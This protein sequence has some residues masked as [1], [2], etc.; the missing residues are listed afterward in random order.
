MDIRRMA[1]IDAPI[2]KVSGVPMSAY[3]CGPD[4]VVILENL[5]EEFS[6]AEFWDPALQAWWSFLDVYLSSGVNPPFTTKYYGQLLAKKDY[7]SVAP[8]FKSELFGEILRWKNTSGSVIFEDYFY[9]DILAFCDTQCKFFISSRKVLGKQLYTPGVYTGTLSDLLARG[10]W[11]GLMCAL[12]L[13]RHCQIEDFEWPAN[14]IATMRE[15]LGEWL[16]KFV[17]AFQNVQSFIGPD[18]VVYQWYHPVVLEVIQ[19]TWSSALLLK[20]RPLVVTQSDVLSLP[21]NIASE[22]VRYVNN[23]PA[24]Y[25]NP[26]AE[27]TVWDAMSALFY[28]EDADAPDFCEKAYTAACVP[29]SYFNRMCDTLYEFYWSVKDGLFTGQLYARKEVAFSSGES[30]AESPAIY[31]EGLYDRGFPAI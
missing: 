2:Q 29:K 11:R 31:L 20:N 23:S 26:Y 28:P 17:Q 21:T 6:T 9:N 18:N 15:K 7:L 14:L 4:K 25:D 22:L 5:L 10:T 8:A 24:V 16:E 13:Y 3:A 19:R 12:V 27:Q 30:D 1:L